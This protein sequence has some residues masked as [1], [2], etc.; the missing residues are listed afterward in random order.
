MRSSLLARLRHA[1]AVWA[2]AMDLINPRPCSSCGGIDAATRA[3]V[4]FPRVVL[5]QPG[6]NRLWW[7]QE[8]NGWYLSELEDRPEGG[9]HARGARPG[10]CP[11]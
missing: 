6:G 8:C 7:C 9:C 4:C 10:R 5:E 11:V 3:G 1:E 2:R